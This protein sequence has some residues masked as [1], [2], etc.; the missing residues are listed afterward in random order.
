M[1]NVPDIGGAEGVEVIEILVQVGDTIEKESPLINLESEKATMEVPAP[2]AGVVKALH[3]KVGDKVAEGSAIVEMD[4][5]MAKTTEESAAT[6]A[7][8]QEITES[9]EPL[10]EKPVEQTSAEAPKQPTAEPT[11][12]VSQEPIYASPVVRRM[13][14]ERSIDLHQ[15]TGSGRKGR[16][17]KEDLYQQPAASS[18]MAMPA[19]AA[20]DFSKFGEITQQP[21]SRINKLSAKNM[22]R[23]WVSAPH[24]TQ[25]DE[26]D[27]TEMEAFRQANKKQAEQQGFKFTPLV[28][29]MKAVVHALKT[30][31]RFNSSLD[32]SG[33]MLIMKNYYHLGIAVD[34]PNGLVVPVIRD[35]DKKGLFILAEE[36]AAVSKKARD[37]KLT[38]RDMQGQCFTISSLGGIDGT[39]FTP[40]INL[41]DVAILGVSKSQ[42]KP[43][44]NGKEFEPRLMLP[45]SLSYD[46]RVIDGA[47]GARFASFLVQCLSD[48]RRLLL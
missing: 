47:V 17:T 3:V 38:A 10:P 28:F 44:Y 30:Y 16:I 48:V 21:L 27:I 8:T 34:T 20:I 4:A 32:G 42:I 22:H 37:G 33:E 36:L 40:I 18:A 29:I 9:A 1:V 6:A 14:R 41:P 19:A 24:V 31:P 2:F 26:A 43:L 11:A 39:A 12:S 46:H 23:N 13:A 45:L 7:E 5:A 25:F 15:V 35:V